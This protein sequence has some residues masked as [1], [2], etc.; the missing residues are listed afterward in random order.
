MQENNKRYKIEKKVKIKAKSFFLNKN[1]S[2]FQIVI[3][4]SSKNIHGTLLIF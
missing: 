2:Y 1:H 3:I 4:V